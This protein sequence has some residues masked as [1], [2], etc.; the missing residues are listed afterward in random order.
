MELAD[1]IIHE[2]HQELQKVKPSAFPIISVDVPR[3]EDDAEVSSEAIDFAG[4]HSHR[5]PAP[6]E[7]FAIAPVDLQELPVEVVE[8]LRRT[9]LYI[10]EELVA[11]RSS[12][13]KRQ[14]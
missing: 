2:L 5:G 9:L 7:N 11:K 10:L 3:S 12:N 1:K 14:N 4:P 13:V 8:K 6:P